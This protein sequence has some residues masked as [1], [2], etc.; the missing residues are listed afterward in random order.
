MVRRSIVIIGIACVFAA[1]VVLVR[2][3]QQTRGS[4]QSPGTQPAVPVSGRTA[5]PQAVVREA[6]TPVL[7]KAVAAGEHS[8]ARESAASV[9]PVPDLRIR[10][11]VDPDISIAQKAADELLR[12]EES[13]VPDLLR[14][15]AGADEPLKGQ[16]LFLLGRAQ[17]RRALPV[18]LQG[19]TEANPY[20]RRNAAEAAGKTVERGAVAGLLSLLNDEDESVRETAAR[21]LGA[22]GDAAATPGLLQRLGIERAEPVKVALAEALGRIKDKSA[23]ALLLAQLRGS[24]NQ[25]YLNTVV[26]ALGEIG[27]NAALGELQLYLDDLKGRKPPIA[28]LLFEWEEA[29]RI[30]EE[31][32][33]AIN[34]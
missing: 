13:A 18:I 25:A 23:T 9:A 19:L 15:Y 12:Q 22:I 33:A 4:A 26:L 10:A 20:L 3:Y 5:S 21:S 6:D 17:D 11:L 27:D 24:G 14:A 32:I 31:A 16:I 8:A 34:R 30:A 7:R 1:A 28:I 2:Q 29:V